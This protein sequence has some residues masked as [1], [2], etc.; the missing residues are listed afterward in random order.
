[1]LIYSGTEN[2]VTAM[3]ASIPVLRPLWSKVRHGYYG[4]NSASAKQG[5]ELG[6]RYG[7]SAGSKNLE[8]ALA[9]NH[10]IHE[11]RIYTGGRKY[12]IENDNASEETILRESNA[13]SHKNN[14]VY[15]RT[16]ISVNYTTANHERSSD[17]DK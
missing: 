3:C 6:G 8:G 16:E 2:F 5:Y 1:M 7:P 17:N 10:G 14:E 9:P 13:Q 11:A 12:D 4:S 15:C